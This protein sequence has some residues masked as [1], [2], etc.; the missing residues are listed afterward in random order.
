MKL[1]NVTTLEDLKEAAVKIDRP[2]KLIFPQFNK[3]TYD[4][5]EGP[6]ADGYGLNKG[7]CA[8]NGVM[9]FVDDG[10]KYVVPI[11]TKGYK[12]LIDEGY[13]CKSM[14]VPFSNW[15]YS[16]EFK[17]QW[18]SLVIEAKG[19]KRKEFEDEC[20]RICDMQHI[21][22]ISKELLDECLEIPDSGLVVTTVHGDKDIVRP[23]F[24][25][26]EISTMI[27]L[28][29]WYTNNSVISFVYRNGKKYVTPNFK[30]LE[31]LQEAGYIEGGMHVPLSNWETIDD[32]MY[33]SRWE[34][35]K[36]R[37]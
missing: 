21:G 23:E 14:T 10:I 37:A 19:I 18:D 7:Y 9:A 20:G 6:K 1:A 16:P 8:N 25:T 31:A 2:I 3:E 29:R 15:D 22:S 35:L 34:E 26:I 36:K 28:G 11:F 17:V 5:W 4:N 30:V 13:T 12:I 24:S 33:A 27:F 32:P